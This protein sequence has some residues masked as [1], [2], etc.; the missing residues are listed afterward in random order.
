MTDKIKNIS[1]YQEPE[2]DKVHDALF[3]KDIEIDEETAERILESYNINGNDLVDE[4]K[5]LLQKEIKENNGIKDK[6]QENENL[7]LFLKDIGNYQRAQSPESIEPKGWIKGI[8]NASNE[9]SLSSSR[10]AFSFHR[11]GK[12]DLTEHDREIIDDL[13][14]ELD[15]DE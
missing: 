12:D 5:L 1:D 7:L 8:L 13:E 15:K 2:T 14:S 9:N 11:R 3:G 10:T 6:E 4:F